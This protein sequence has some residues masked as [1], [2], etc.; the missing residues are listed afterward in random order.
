M[1]LAV[2]GCN[3]PGG[4]TVQTPAPAPAPAPTPSPT[5]TPTPTPAAALYVA[6]TIFQVAI[7]DGLF[8]DNAAPGRTIPIRVR[9]PANFRPAPGEKLPVI[10]WSHG[11]VPKV[12]GH[13]KNEDWGNALAAAGYV[14]IHLGHVPRTDA[15]IT[16]LYAE[17][18]LTRQQGERCFVYLLVD[19]PRDAAAAIRDLGLIE[20]QI[21]GLPAPFDLAR[22]AVAGHS[23]GSYTVR[24]IS[25]ARVD[26]CP[27]AAAIPG[28]PAN[29]P[30]RNTSFRNEMPIAFMA[31]SPQGPGRFG[32]FDKSWA[33]LDRPDITMSGDG[34]YVGPSPGV[35]EQGEQPSD[36]IIPYHS[37]PPGDKYLMY[38]FSPEATH[39]TF[40]LGDG[41]RGD[42]KAAVRST[43]IAFMDAYL[44]NRA[45]A[46][47]WL[48]NN[49]LGRLSSGLAIVE[50]R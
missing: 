35:D 47:A 16:A 46:R 11:G 6:P 20:A 22:V 15:Q 3:G 26:L 9:Y 27:T 45:V 13:L 10:I 23:L 18:G 34:D 36:R 21:P 12:D 2:P 42:F 7:K 19:R 43:G 41:A 32:F 33:G 24:T 49:E 28:F 8:V 44:S 31:L 37:M 14:V 25:G 17:Y 30:Y 39:E 1:I 40:D 5:P 48:T 4:G 29:W 38:I 50:T